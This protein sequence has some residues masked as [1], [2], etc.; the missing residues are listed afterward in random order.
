[1]YHLN[2]NELHFLTS[3]R[4]PKNVCVSYTSKGKK[5]F[6]VISFGGRILKKS[7]GKIIFEFSSRYWLVIGLVSTPPCRM[8]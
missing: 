6:C 3:H 1:M 8:L 2:L 7:F 4:F 5:I